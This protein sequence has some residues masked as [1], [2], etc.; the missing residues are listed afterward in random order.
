MVFSIEGVFEDRWKVSWVG[1]IGV[2][3]DI[4]VLRSFGFV[5]FRDCERSNS[6]YIVYFFF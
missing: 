2:V 6:I 4:E 1:C 5:F 3:C